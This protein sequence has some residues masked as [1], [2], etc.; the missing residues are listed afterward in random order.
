MRYSIEGGSLPVVICQL[1]PGEIMISESGGRTWARGNLVTETSSEGG[2]GK[3]FGR[4]VSGESLFLSRYSAQGPVEIAFASSFPGRIIPKELGTGPEH[5]L[6]EEGFSGRHGRRDAVRLFSEKARPRPLRR[7]GFYY[8]EGHRA[9]LR[10]FWRW[11]ATAWNTR[12]SPANAWFAIPA[13]WPS[14]KK[15]A[16]WTYRWSRA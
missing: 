10:P 12:S 3:M 7:R 5:H 4:M 14:W 16:P 11:T 9:R 2:L 15:P 13:S 8:A 1:D 6:P